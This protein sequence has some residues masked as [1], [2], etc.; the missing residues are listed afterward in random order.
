MKQKNLLDKAA[1]EREIERIRH[2]LEALKSTVLGSA[3]ERSSEK[4][5]TTNE[6]GAILAARRRR[7][8]MFGKGLFADPAWDILL[9]L[10]WGELAQRRFLTT[11]L[12]VRSA[13]PPTTA[14]RW[15]EKLHRDGWVT[16]ADDQDDGRR[17]WVT[18]SARGIETMHQYFRML[19]ATPALI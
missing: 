7:E 18:L 2:E 8:E 10:Y 4:S 14:L 11:E 19:E 16:R 3:P 5:P 12:G 1:M 9:E 13:V 6:V 17:V 15:I